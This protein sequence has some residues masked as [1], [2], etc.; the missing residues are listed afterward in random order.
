MDRRRWLKMAVTGMTSLLSP[1]ALA[2]GEAT[3]FAVGHL[4][5]GDPYRAGAWIRLAMELTQRTSVTC[6]PRP[7]LLEIQDAALFRHPL[8]VLSGDRMPVWEDSS[9]Q[10]LQRYLQGGGFLFIDGRGPGDPLVAQAF[11]R[12]AQ[13]FRPEA[14][15]R[16]DREHVLYRSFYLLDGP[17]GRR[18]SREPA[19]ALA[20]DGRL[21]VLATEVDLAGALARDAYG[22]WSF[23]MPSTDREMAVRF[24]V[25][26]AMYA[27]CTDYKAD[28]VH[29]PFLLKRRR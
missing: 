2:F 19:K 6:Q 21:A 4:G 9:W 29:I 18:S 11:D 5:G 13:S 27:L 28:Q 26:V 25:N 14:N 3:R 16:L 12:L 17:R 23:D 7:T 24:G 8:V 10:R 22:A 1:G 15:L 20:L